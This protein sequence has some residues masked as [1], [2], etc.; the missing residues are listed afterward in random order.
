[1]G[2]IKR[3]SKESTRNF[4]SPFKDYWNRFNYILLFAGIAALILGY[5]LMTIGPWDN[6]IS[7]SIS[8]VVLLIGYLI[9]IPLAI[10][11]IPSKKKKDVS[12]ES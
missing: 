4:I 6:P 12:S 11:F 3:V 2:K 9:I 8:P 7:L 1:M 10:L 5:F